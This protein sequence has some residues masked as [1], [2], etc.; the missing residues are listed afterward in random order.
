MST[1]DY[2]QNLTRYWQQYQPQWEIPA[3]FHVHHIKPKST[4]ADK[5]DPRINHPSN[6]I[7][8]H[9]DDHYTIH[10]LRGDKYVR[11]GFMTVCGRKTPMS[12][13]TKK[14]LSAAHTGKKLSVATKQKISVACLGRVHSAQTK[15]KI[16]QANTG[17]KLTADQKQHLS[18]LNK[19]GKRTDDIKKKISD[20]AT[21]QYASGKRKSA[22]QGRK[23]TIE[24]K[25][26][27]KLA[28]AKRRK[29]NI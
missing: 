26:K 1:L 15:E 3:G 8:L 17:K 14:K 7:A 19:G 10:K 2:K 28:W 23:H 22:V 21:A 11:K 6:L 5:N 27:M 12:A 24:A 9:P 29:E 25:K 18:D 13:E 20:T 16:R 4:F